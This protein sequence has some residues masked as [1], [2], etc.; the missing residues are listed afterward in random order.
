M[1]CSDARKMVLRTHPPQVPFFLPS[2]HGVAFVSALHR[3]VF[4]VAADGTGGAVPNSG[5]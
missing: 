1:I 5:T 4:G 2:E 3:P